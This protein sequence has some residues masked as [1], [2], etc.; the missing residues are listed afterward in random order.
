MKEKIHTI[1]LGNIYYWTNLIDKEKITLVFLPGLTADHR[2]FE[3]QLEYFE[4]KYNVFVWDAPGHNLSWPFDFNFNLEDKAKWLNDILEKEGI[5]YP[6]IVGQSMGGYVGQMYAQL[7]PD[8]LKGFVSIDSAPLQKKYVTGIERWLLKKMEP[9]YYYYPWKSLVKAGT[10]GVAVSEYG[11]KLMHD[12]MMT[13]DGDKKRYSKLAGH[14]YR[15]LAEAMERDLPYTINCPAILICGEKD[16][17]GSCIRYNKAWHRNTNIPI[18][19]I[20]DAGHNSNTDK[21]DVV[22][23]LIEELIKIIC[24]RK[25][26]SGILDR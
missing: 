20:K 21:P 23:S 12:I 17:A 7:Y 11:R 15:I 18:K 9:V 2:L 19:W 26:R 1:P 6:V 8:K 25:A 5:K 24:N 14:G 4:Y 10:K 13:Y 3:K 16:K 22:N